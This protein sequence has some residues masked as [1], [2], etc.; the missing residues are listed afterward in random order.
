MIDA[1]RVIAALELD[2][3][4]FARGMDDAIRAA[5][6]LGGGAQVAASG[7]SALSK[8]MGDMKKTAQLSARGAKDAL[9]SL[10]GASAQ[11]GGDAIDGLITG[12]EGRRG[13]LVAKFKSLA[14]AAIQAAKAELGIASPSKVFAEIG[15]NVA[16]SMATGIDKN[17]HIAQD[18]MRRLVATSAL[19]PSAITGAGGVH[20]AGSIVSHNYNA[21]PVTVTFPG[22]VVR[23]DNDIRTLEKRMQ[24]LA[25][26]LN[27]GLGARST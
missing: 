19:A 2:D 11:A 20:P 9:D 23:T 18:A 14:A 4:G 6:A 22:A 16:G 13:A 15:A 21:A 3:S 17:R 24:R 25:R 10:A 8:A 7:V 27:Y 5:Q 12:A 1:G 26:E